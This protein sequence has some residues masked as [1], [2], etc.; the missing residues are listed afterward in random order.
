MGLGLALWLDEQSL[1]MMREIRLRLRAGFSVSTLVM[2]VVS[3][4]SCYR[5]TSTLVRAREVRIRIWSTVRG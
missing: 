2:V 5:S 1:M 4:R 3:I